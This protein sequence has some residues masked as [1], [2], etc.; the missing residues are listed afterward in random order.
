MRLEKRGVSFGWLYLLLFMLTTAAIIIAVVPPGSWPDNAGNSFVAKLKSI[1]IGSNLIPGLKTGCTQLGESECLDRMS[2][3]CVPVYS[4][5]SRVF[6][7]CTTC[8]K[9][10][11]CSMFEK[12]EVCI[13][14]PC[15]LNCVWV[16][17]H[18]KNGYTILGR[19]VGSLG[20]MPLK[21]VLHD[22]GFN[23]SALPIEDIDG[24][25]RIKETDSIILY[26]EKN[27]VLLVDKNQ[28]DYIYLKIGK[29]GA[30]AID[31]NGQVAAGMEER[32][33]ET[34]ARYV[35]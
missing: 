11:S 23:A 16:T 24:F 32:A 29:A 12:D 19:C 14:N 13:Y 7:D 33:E 9:Y 18:Y 5:G 20:E 15:G 30:A 6:L 8:T 25:R 34:I 21:D 1:N 28:S 3:G 26:K 31:K 35:V 17:G 2:R 22:Y 4:S 10:P 27:N